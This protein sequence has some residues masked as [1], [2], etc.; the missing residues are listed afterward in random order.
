MNRIS[1]RARP[2][3]KDLGL[4]NHE[5]HSISWFGRATVLALRWEFLLFVGATGRSPDRPASFCGGPSKPPG[6]GPSQPMLFEPKV[7]ASG[8]QASF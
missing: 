2:G 4:K 1:G 6:I 8:P 7:L 5:A 3:R